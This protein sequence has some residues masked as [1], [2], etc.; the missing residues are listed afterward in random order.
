MPSDLPKED[1]N[2]TVSFLL[3]KSTDLLDPLT[4][5]YFMLFGGFVPKPAKFSLEDMNDLVDQR[6]ASRKVFQEI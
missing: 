3:R 4:R 2:Q 1:A 6:A 5:H